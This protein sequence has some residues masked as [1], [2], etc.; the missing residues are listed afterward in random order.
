[1][2]PAIGKTRVIVSLLCLMTA[3]AL[4]LVL[5]S[6]SSLGIEQERAGQAQELYPSQFFDPEDE[7]RLVGFA[8]NV[9]VGRVLEQVSA[10]GTP[11]ILPEDQRYP[12]P[13]PVIPNTQFSVEVQENV[14]G[15]LEGVVTVSQTGGYDPSSDAMVLMQGDRLLEVGQTL[16][17][18]S[19]FDEANKWHVIAAQPQGDVRVKDSGQRKELVTKFKK[20]KDEQIDPQAEISD[21]LDEPYPP[22]DKDAKY[23]AAP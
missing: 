4:T 6:P 15:K 5:V 22:R 14:K 7:R 10:E 8:D 12:G 2:T 13:L 16:L 9:F 20:A 3:G 19:R 1:M 11:T 17:F 23:K 18:V 21:S